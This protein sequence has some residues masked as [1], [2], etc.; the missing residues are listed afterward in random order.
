MKAR[1]L[2]NTPSI[3]WYGRLIKNWNIFN[4]NQ[5]IDKQPELTLSQY[6][7][8]RNID[9]SGRRKREVDNYIESI[10]CG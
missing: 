2:K 3:E 8:N 9:L 6:A 4:K 10:N 1:S 5:R 7:Y